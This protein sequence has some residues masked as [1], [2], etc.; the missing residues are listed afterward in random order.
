MVH[1]GDLARAREALSSAD[2][3]PEDSDPEGEVRS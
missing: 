2:S 3:I 1:G